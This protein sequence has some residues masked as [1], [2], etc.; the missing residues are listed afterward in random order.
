MPEAGDFL[1]WIVLY[2]N[3]LLKLQRA[4]ELFA[5]YSFS[6]KF[7]HVIILTPLHS[8][9]CGVKLKTLCIL[10]MCH[11][12][13]RSVSFICRLLY[14]LKSPGIF[15]TRGWMR[16]RRQKSPQVIDYVENICLHVEVRDL[17]EKIYVFRYCL[18][19]YPILKSQ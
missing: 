1:E 14:T 12:W 4:L 18:F 13:E 7:I 5:P 8:D 9:W 6:C 3:K 2:T 17:T 15:W 11:K 19:L 10:K 16:S